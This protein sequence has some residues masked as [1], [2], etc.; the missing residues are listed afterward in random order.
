MAPKWR[1]AAAIL[2]VAALG[3]ALW[4]VRRGAVKSEISLH[5]AAWWGD[6]PAVE[7]L[8]A[9]GA[10]V[11]AKDDGGWTPLHWAAGRHDEQVAE[12][13]IA[14]GADVNAKDNDGWTP[15]R[16][17]AKEDHPDIAELLRKHGGRE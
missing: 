12:L 10:D 1:C 4:A 5:D 13:L 6:K 15:L 11:N 2:A 3:P 16:I 8:I 9:Q 7:R 14:K 17:A